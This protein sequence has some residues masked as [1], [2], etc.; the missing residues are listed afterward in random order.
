MNRKTALVLIERIKSIFRFLLSVEMVQAAEKLLET[1]H[2]RQ[3]FVA[4]AEMVFSEL[5]VAYP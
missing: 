4:V 5:P 3:I 1:V 2:G